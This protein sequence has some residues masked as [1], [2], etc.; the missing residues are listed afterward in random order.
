MK[1]G[2]I[3][4]I[5]C[6]INWFKMV[7]YLLSE[8]NYLYNQICKSH[9]CIKLFINYMT[10]KIYNVIYQFNDTKII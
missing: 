9:Q 7:R 4:Q 8:K 10:H 2:S 5:I 1:E 3:L 6:K